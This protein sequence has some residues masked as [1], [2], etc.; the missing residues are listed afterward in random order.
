MRRK[1]EQNWKDG[2]GFLQILRR[3]NYHDLGWS[4]DAIKNHLDD[5]LLT[6][7]EK[8]GGRVANELDERFPH[9]LQCHYCPLND[10]IMMSTNIMS[11]H[12]DSG[13]DLSTLLYPVSL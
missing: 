8:V 13:V 6:E 2:L 9:H 11:C 1:D 7:E 5:D 3:E 4:D 10:L 12:D